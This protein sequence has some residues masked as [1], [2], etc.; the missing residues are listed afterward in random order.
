MWLWRRTRD[1]EIL[2]VNETT[3]LILLRTL[4][5]DDA[6]ALSVGMT[7]N[8]EVLTRSAFL[9]FQKVL[10]QLF[11]YL[12][13]H[14]LGRFDSIVGTLCQIVTRVRLTELCSGPLRGRVI[15]LE[16]A[17]TLR[18]ATTFDSHGSSTH[19]PSRLALFHTIPL[20]IRHCIFIHLMCTFLSF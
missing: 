5:R 15:H 4:R 13:L 19:L 11:T 12:T 14:L 17:W 1:D 9:L 7:A 8:P 10:D 20:S 18:S 2:L 6:Y 3:T 16:G